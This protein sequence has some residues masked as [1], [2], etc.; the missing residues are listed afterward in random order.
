MAI[1]NFLDEMSLNIVR[2][3]VELINVNWLIKLQAKL[4]IVDPAHSSAHLT[5]ALF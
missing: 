5:K 3:E 2:P 1:V 4:S